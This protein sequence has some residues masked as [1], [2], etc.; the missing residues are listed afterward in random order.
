[1]SR[2]EKDIRKMHTDFRAEVL[3]LIMRYR[4]EPR[5]LVEK[6]A[7]ALLEIS[8]ADQVVYQG[9]GTKR[10][11]VNAEGL[12][13]LGTIPEEY[14]AG[15]PHADIHN[16]VYKDGYTMMNDCSKGYNGIHV[17]EKCPVK[18]AMK[19][20]LYYEGKPYGFLAVNYIR[21][22]HEFTEMGRETFNQI[23]N[24]FQITYA[25]INA[26]QQGRRAEAVR[27]T[28]GASSSTTT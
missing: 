27:M 20:L 23:C 25:E 9:E 18:S 19:Q 22:Y 6:M 4:N 14:C 16:E 3:E 15:C 24:V 21:D 10:I 11:T 8:G 7:E 1:M 17:H 12:G 13:E 26:E 2:S 28:I 5:T